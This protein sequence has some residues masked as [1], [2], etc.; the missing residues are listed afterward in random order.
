[1]PVA[2]DLAELDACLRE[3]RARLHVP[4]IVLAVD[5][6][7]ERH[8]VADGVAN[9]ETREGVARETSFRIASIT[10]PFVAALAVSLADAG[11]LDL[12]AP[13]AGAAT[14]RQLLSH[15]GGLACEW[16]RPLDAYGDRDDA[17]A[18]LAED[19]PARLPVGPGE[20]FSYSNAGY[21]L[22]GAAIA[23]AT[24]ATFEAAMLERLLF[25]LGLRCTGFAPSRPPARGYEQVDPGADEH[26]PADGEYPRARRPGGGLWSTVD[27]LLRFGRF[28]ADQPAMHEPLVPTAEGSWGLG[29]GLGEANGRRTVDH[30]GS[31]A[32]FQSLLLL[33]PDEGLVLAALT[34]SSRGRRVIRAALELLGLY[35]APEPSRRADGELAPFAGRYRDEWMDVRVR[36]E[37]GGLVLDVTWTDVFKD[38]RIEFPPVRAEATGPTTFVVVE[39]DD[40]GD[41]ID[42]PRPGLGRFGGLVVP[43]SPD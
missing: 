2:L 18:R 1:V 41:P 31:A 39:G 27:D 30:R 33:V 9:R 17:L 40:E 37:D 8:V 24:A 15:Q 23:R 38:Q 35:V 5:H 4:G 36:P 13:L 10:K 21:W 14:A 22:V 32:G 3:E 20:L 16:P 7:G 26:R 25:P 42:F 11:L 12:D 43:R 19:E 28:L 34:N 29:I 6:D